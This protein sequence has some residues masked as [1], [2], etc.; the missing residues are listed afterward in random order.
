MSK[1]RGS[2]RVSLRLTPL[3][4]ARV[5]EE[6]QRL[7]YNPLVEQ[8]TMTTYITQAIMEKIAHSERGRKTRKKAKKAS[9][10]TE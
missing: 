10:S 2:P 5:K 8:L 7:N 6:V 1:Q 4:L 3:I 9:T